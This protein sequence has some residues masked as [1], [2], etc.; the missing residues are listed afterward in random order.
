M[1]KGRPRRH[2][3]G[4]GPRRRGELPPRRGRS[5]STAIASGT[6][7]KRDPTLS[8]WGGRPVPAYSAQEARSLLH[9]ILDPVANAGRR[10]SST[11]SAWA[12]KP[13]RS[14]RGCPPSPGTSC[15]LCLWAHQHGGMV[16]PEDRAQ[17]IFFNILYCQTLPNPAIETKKEISPPSNLYWA[18]PLHHLAERP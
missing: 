4:S 8:P 10:F 11:S 1:R 5:R 14:A 17:S 3:S 18:V 12:K 15:Y 9:A 6:R 7:G 2:R 13:T 16:G